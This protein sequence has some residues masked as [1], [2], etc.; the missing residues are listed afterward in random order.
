MELQKVSGNDIPGTIRS[1]GRTL[2]LRFHS[3]FLNVGEGFS[4]NIEFLEA[5][6]ISGMYVKSVKA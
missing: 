4:L 6:P 2:L 5:Q 3:D 1:R